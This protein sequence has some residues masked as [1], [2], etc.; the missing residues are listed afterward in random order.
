MTKNFSDY[1]QITNFKPHQNYNW[2]TSELVKWKTFTG[3]VTSGVLYKP[4]DFDPQKKYPVIFSIY[5]RQ[6]D[7]LNTFMEP[8]LS[9]SSINIPYF[10]SRGY[11]VFCPD[12]NYEV[13]NVGHSAYDYVISAAQSFAKMPWVD[14]GK[15]GIQGHSFGGYEVNYLITQI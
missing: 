8:G 3:N 10:V 12:I 2:L 6:S 15:M 1:F 7:R 13:G 9:S 4:Q 14:K 11:L 5:E